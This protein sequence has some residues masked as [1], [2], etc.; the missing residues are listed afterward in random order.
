[1]KTQNLKFYVLFVTVVGSL[2][3]ISWNTIQKSKAT[4]TSKINTLTK[5]EIK[6]GWKLL[7][8]GKTFNGWRGLGRDHVPNGLWVIENGLIKKVNTGEC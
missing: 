3:F 4:T 1:M 6:E 8:D 7:F 2:L 5:A